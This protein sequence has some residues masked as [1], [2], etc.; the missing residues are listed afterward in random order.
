MKDA[1]T[2]G[3]GGDAP[4]YG[5][6]WTGTPRDQPSRSWSNSSTVRV[7][8]RGPWFIFHFCTVLKVRIRRQVTLR[9]KLASPSGSARVGGKA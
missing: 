5:S 1:A 2:V 9:A 8:G 7:H 4:A 3:A 6:G